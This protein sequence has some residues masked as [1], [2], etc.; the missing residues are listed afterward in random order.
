MERELTSQAFIRLLERLGE[1]EEQAAQKYEDLRRT[2]IRFFE[3]RGAPFPEE[4]A[5]EAFNRLARKL[6]E[7]VEIQNVN[8]Y[9]YSVAR[10]VWLETLKGV[11]KRRESLEEVQ[12][13]PIAHEPSREDDEKENS[14]DCLDDCLDALPYANRDLIMEY[15][16]DEKRGRI[17]R[18]RDLAERLGLR[19]D[20]LAN[21]AQRLRDKLEQCVTRCLQK[22]QRYTRRPFATSN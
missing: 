16:V 8:D 20:A 21:R 19:R 10:L 2:L 1:D 9:S 18:R 4:H 6:D 15:Y 13:E 11:D 14:L 5:D 12:H 22:K 17:D 3:W 7:G